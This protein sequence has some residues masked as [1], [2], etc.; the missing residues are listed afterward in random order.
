MALQKKEDFCPSCYIES[1]IDVPLIY[2]L[3]STQPLKCKNDHVFEDRE[4]LSALTKSMLDQKKALAPKAEKPAPT[5]EIQPDIDEDNK[6]GQSTDPLPTD[7]VKGMR[8][9]PVDM[10][11]LTTLLGPFRDSS[12]LVG[13]I[14]SLKQELADSKDLLQ[15]AA[16]KAA[17]AKIPTHGGPEGAAPRKIGGD[18]IVQLVIPERHVASLND[19]SAANGMDISRYM[20]AKVEDG[21]DNMW[22]Y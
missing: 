11:R 18:E 1:G 21:L 5:E 4:E 12:T 17:I 3:G 20:N 6:I 14:Y 8:I 2:N 7:G 16:D 15:R 22:Y 9:P 10:V 13:K 19:I